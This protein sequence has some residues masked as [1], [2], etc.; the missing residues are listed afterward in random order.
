M[1]A[2]DIARRSAY[3]RLYGVDGYLDRRLGPDAR[4]LDVGCS[5]G[6]AARSC[7]DV[8]RMASTSTVRPSCPHVMR[9]DVSR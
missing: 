1:I 3:Y 4:V 2:L 7:G 6:R 5:D 8:G 9:A